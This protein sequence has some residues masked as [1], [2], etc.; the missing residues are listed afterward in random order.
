MNQHLIDR[1]GYCTYNRIDVW[2]KR[3]QEERDKK[4]TTM[5]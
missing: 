3:K 4:K 2:L 5:V 1:G